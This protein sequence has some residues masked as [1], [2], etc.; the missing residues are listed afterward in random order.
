MALGQRDGRVEGV[1]VWGERG[2]HCSYPTAE[3]I[4]CANDAYGSQDSF[5]T[6]PA[7]DIVLMAA[8][9]PGYTPNEAELCFV[10]KAYE[11]SSAFLTI[12][13]GFDAPLRAG[14][15]NGKTATAPRFMLETLRTE[16]PG[17]KWVE[18]RWAR[19]G[20]LWTSGAL[21]NGLDLMVAFVRDT[22]ANM[23]EVI[24]AMVEL[25][26]WPDRGAEYP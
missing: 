25:G 20:K 18:K 16:A 4:P 7:L 2:V 5:E 12:C 10:R 14:L 24:N 9:R 22:Y 8:H 3:E 13:G 21:L 23:P 26:G 6:C 15:L 1:D 17:T 11:D 19:D